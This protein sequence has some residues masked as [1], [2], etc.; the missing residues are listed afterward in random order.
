[1]S[2]LARLMRTFEHMHNVQEILR[3]ILL[4]ELQPQREIVI[5]Q[6]AVN[7]A[8]DVALAV[9]VD[10]FFCRHVDRRRFSS[11][12]RAT[13]EEKTGDPAST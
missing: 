5:Q 13:R 1:M 7:H 11:S 4:E 8:F 2:W 6:P 12:G 3:L 10:N 9:V